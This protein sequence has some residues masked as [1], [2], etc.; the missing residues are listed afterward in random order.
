M[1]P[2]ETSFAISSH[3]SLGVSFAA[4]TVSTLEAV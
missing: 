3:L 1:L 4:L 2:S